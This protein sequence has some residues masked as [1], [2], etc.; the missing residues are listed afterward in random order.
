[1]ERCMLLSANNIDTEIDVEPY[2]SLGEAQENMLSQVENLKNS[3][4]FVEEE[5]ISDT[6]ASLYTGG[7]YGDLFYW[8]IKE[9]EV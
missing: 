5:N 2:K 1:M 6:G 4:D 7:E 3:L 8:Q 9:I